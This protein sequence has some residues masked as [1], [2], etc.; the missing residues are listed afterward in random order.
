M[1]ERKFGRLARQ[2]LALLLCFGGALGASAEDEQHP[3]NPPMTQTHMES[4]LRSLAPGAAGVSGALSF[5]FDGVQIECISD[6]EHN[7]MRLVAAIG[8]VSDLTAE[9]VARILEANF[10]TALDA[11]YAT[12]NGYLYAAFIHPLSPLTE[13]ELRSAVSQVSNLAQAFGTTY[14]SGELVYGGNGPPI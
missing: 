14:S 1:R 10:H 4:L 11:R 3:D 13:G 8:P 6:P 9:H 7:R 2:V 12:S 5:K